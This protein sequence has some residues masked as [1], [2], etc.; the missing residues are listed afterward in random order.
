MR[1][2]RSQ[3]IGAVKTVPNSTTQFRHEA[4]FYEGED[5]LVSAALPFLREGVDRGEPA[6][7]VLGARKLERLREELGGTEGIQ[8][9]DMAVVGRNPARIIP[10]WHDFVAAHGGPGVRVRGLGEPVCSER[11]ADELAECQR[12]ES[13]LNLAFAEA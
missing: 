9:A 2:E 6:L 10:A 11:S 8:F 4:L 12:H 3:V 1:H 7:V 13:L 5:E